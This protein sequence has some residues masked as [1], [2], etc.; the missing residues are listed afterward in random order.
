MRLLLDRL[1]PSV[2]EGVIKGDVPLGLLLS[3]SYNDRKVVVKK[4]FR[5]DECSFVWKAL[6][7]HTVSQNPNKST[8]PPLWGRSAV[9]Y[10]DGEPLIHVLEV[11]PPK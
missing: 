8:A 3:S 6:G 4:L 7:V 2:R 9:I 11:L 10:L 1:L 5:L